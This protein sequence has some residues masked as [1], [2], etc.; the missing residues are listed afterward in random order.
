MTHIGAWNVVSL[1]VIVVALLTWIGMVLHAGNW[2]DPRLT[3]IH[4]RRAESDQ[5]PQASAAHEAGRAAGEFGDPNRPT[6]A[7]TE[8]V[9]ASKPER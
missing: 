4:R 5:T 7:E 1:I 2:Q 8:E 6:P 9:G 3:E